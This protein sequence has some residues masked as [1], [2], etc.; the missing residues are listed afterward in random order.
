RTHELAKQTREVGLIA[1][2]AI[3]CDMAKRSIALPHQLL[4]VLNAPA[5]NVDE[6]S[7]AE[8]CLEGTK[9]MSGAHSCE[10]NEIGTP[11]SLTEILLDISYQAFHLPTRHL[12]AKYA[13]CLRSDVWFQTGGQ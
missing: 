7:L 10:R 1:Q 12:T 4:C 11:D 8:S 6:G 3:E 9:K 13:L 2:P 5:C